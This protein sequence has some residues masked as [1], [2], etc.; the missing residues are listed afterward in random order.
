[1][2]A[3]C[4]STDDLAGSVGTI[5]MLL[6]RGLPSLPVGAIAVPR[7]PRML[8]AILLQRLPPK[9]VRL[10]AFIH[11]V[12]SIHE[13]PDLDCGIEREQPHNSSLPQELP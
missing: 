9:L 10:A 2:F 8:R 12:A 6:E 7:M 4:L 11:W 13:G 5:T 3:V 1:M